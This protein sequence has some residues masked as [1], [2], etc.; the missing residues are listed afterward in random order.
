MSV[1]GCFE[2]GKSLPRDSS[3]SAQ[4]LLHPIALVNTRSASLYYLIILRP[5]FNKKHNEEIMIA[6]STLAARL[7]YC[8]LQLDADSK[9]NQ[10]F[11]FQGA[12]NKRHSSQACNKA[13]STLGA[14]ENT[15]EMSPL[16]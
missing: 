7:Q 16:H 2:S 12:R 5:P 9:G 4:F 8:R 15:K 1:F 3:N 11:A 10:L 13:T 14:L 6:N